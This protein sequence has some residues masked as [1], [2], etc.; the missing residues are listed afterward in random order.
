MDVLCRTVAGRL[1]AVDGTAGADGDVRG[2]SL[3]R[4]RTPPRPPVAAP[5]TKGSPR[6]RTG[7]RTGRRLVP[8]KSV[9]RWPRP[10]IGLPV[11]LIPDGVVTCRR[12]GSRPRFFAGPGVSNGRML[13]DGR[14]PQPHAALGCPGRP[15]SRRV[16]SQPRPLLCEPA[17]T[18]RR[19]PRQP[20]SPVGGSARHWRSRSG[21][22]AGPCRSACPQLG[23]S[24]SPGAVTSHPPSPHTGR[25]PPRTDDGEVTTS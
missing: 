7:A 13:T 9:P 12:S 1:G 4:H 23:P 25:V 8:R 20:E 16:R 18:A 24:C 15:G 11:L 17:M 5:S 19:E 6:A 2:A 21:W 10:S 22:T 3:A 14:R